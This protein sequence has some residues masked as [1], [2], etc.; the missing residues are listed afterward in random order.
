[1]GCSYFNVWNHYEV[2]ANAKYNVALWVEVSGGWVVDKCNTSRMQ[3]R[4][5]KIYTNKRSCFPKWLLH[6]VIPSP[7]LTEGDTGLLLLEE[8]PVQGCIHV[9]R[10]FKR[11][12]GR[13]SHDPIWLGFLSDWCWLPCL[14]L[15]GKRPTPVW[16]PQVYKDGGGG[17]NKTKV[18]HQ[19]HWNLQVQDWRQQWQNTQ[20]KSP[21]HPLLTWFEEVPPVAPTLGAGG[22]RQ[23]SV[24]KRHTDGKQWRIL[25]SDLGANKIQENDTLQSQ[26]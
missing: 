14:S 2:I 7:L 11:S 10:A 24:A 1:M 3:W 5:F 16:R 15:H 12:Q 6:W 19:R 20:N 21:K 23:L 9:L 25:H 13:H 22:K 17:R 8:A 4:V 26:F 18:R